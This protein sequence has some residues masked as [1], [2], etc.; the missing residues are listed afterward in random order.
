MITPCGRS[1]LTDGQWARLKPLLPKC[2]KPGRPLV[3][4]RAVATRYDKLAVHYE[5]TV[6]VKVLNE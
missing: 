6:L 4:S 3:W 1:E 5:V 2:V